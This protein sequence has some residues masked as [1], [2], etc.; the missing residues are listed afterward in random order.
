M[1]I[2]VFRT[3]LFNHDLVQ[4]AGEHLD[5]M[6]GVSRWN[7]DMHDID[8]IL[9]IEA[10]QVSP[11]NVEEALQKAGYFCEELED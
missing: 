5:A 8:F 4:R 11:R 9:R 6:H 2:L 10:E 1:D 7:V 3:N